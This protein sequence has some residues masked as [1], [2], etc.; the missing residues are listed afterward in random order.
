MLPSISPVLREMVVLLAPAVCC[1]GPS[2]AQARP[3][4]ADAPA[5]PDPAGD[6]VFE[7]GAG[8]P[9]IRFPRAEALRYKVYV[10][11]AF[12]STSAG[13]VTQ[14]ATVEEQR[15]LLLLG[16]TDSA[17]ETACVRLHANGG[18]F[19]YTVESTIESRILP[20]E[21]PRVLYTVRNEGTEKRRRE[22]FLGRRDGAFTSSYRKDTSKGAPEGTRI[23]REA[24]FRTVPEGTLD[25]VSA[26]F[27]VRTLI[28]ENREQISFPLLENDRVWLL[29]LR[30]GEQR[31]METRAGTFAV[32][33]VV[34]EPA[35]YPGETYGDD[36]LEKF[37]G[38]FG[39]HGEMHLWAEAHSGI[40][41]RIQG[42]LPVGLL[43]L[44]V[45]VVLDSYSGTCSDFKSVK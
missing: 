16:Q 26:V 40:V 10:G 27:M 33:E 23:W 35:V 43:T 20:Q 13:N 12:L 31:N 24:K 41:V 11:V 1:F 3:T 9:A 30:R 18:N 5:D 37:E 42:D 36:P 39:I 34:M 29:T 7:T 4:P 25:M 38:L 45:D 19:A 32:E 8:Q 15:P 22:I 44:A 6:L 14:T 2:S 28:R 21:W 17:G